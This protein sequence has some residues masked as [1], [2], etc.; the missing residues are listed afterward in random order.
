MPIFIPA[1]YRQL[2]VMLSD[3]RYKIIVFI[4][5]IRLQCSIIL[6]GRSLL[7]QIG[8]CLTFWIDD[9][10]KICKKPSRLVKW[11]L[12]LTLLRNNIIKT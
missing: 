11:V 7:V 2:P 5:L 3:V 6:N 10:F 12:Y 4:F 8:F 1:A 9:L